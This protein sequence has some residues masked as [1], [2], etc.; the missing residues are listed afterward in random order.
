MIVIDD[1]LDL[2]NRNLYLDID[3]KKYPMSMLY[4]VADDIFF[5]YVDLH[6]D[7]KV[8]NIDMLRQCLEAEALNSC[9]GGRYIPSPNEQDR[10][11]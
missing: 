7:N 3:G 8:N 1:I 6:D 5:F 11:L 4:Y 9:W 2:K 10:K